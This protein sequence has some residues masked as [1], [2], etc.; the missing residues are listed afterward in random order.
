MEW[1]LVRETQLILDMHNL[2]KSIKRNVVIENEYILDS[3]LKFGGWT[4]SN[5]PTGQ[6]T[7]S[8][9]APSAL[10]LELPKVEGPDTRCVETGVLHFSRSWSLG[11]SRKYQNL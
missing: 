7:R 4:R 8:T 6:S 1:V 10:F 5:E 3:V 11:M 2:I 9:Q